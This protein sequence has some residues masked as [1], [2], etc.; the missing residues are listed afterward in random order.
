[1]SKTVKA[2]AWLSVP[3]PPGSRTFPGLLKVTPTGKKVVSLELPVQFFLDTSTTEVIDTAARKGYQRPT[4]HSRGKE[5][6]EHL[7][8]HEVV[9]PVIG[10]IRDVDMKQVYVRDLHGVNAQKTGHVRVT[11]PPNV[12]TRLIDGG[13]RQ[14]GYHYF[15]LRGLD[16]PEDTVSV[17]LHLGLTESA[18][19]D[20]FRTIN[21]KAVRLATNH[22]R[23]LEAY[24]YEGMSEKEA[25]NTLEPKEYDSF[26]RDRIIEDLE[27]T[28]FWSG[29]MIHRTGTNSGQKIT[30]SAMHGSLEPVTNS[31]NLWDAKVDDFVAILT[32]Y[33]EAIAYVFPDAF[34]GGPER[35]KDWAI[36]GGSAV[37]G[38][39]L[40]LPRL[41]DLLQRA[42][43]P[44]DD[45]SS[46]HPYLKRLEELEYSNG[47]Q[48]PEDVSGLNF[49]TKGKDGAVGRFSNRGNYVN[50]AEL[51]FNTITSD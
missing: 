10:N 20:E 37:N 36:Q 7:H 28:E 4:Q 25:K 18:E 5:L 40:I 11:L 49:F 33:W 35:A 14:L 46:Y 31:P 47:H 16:A 22:T 50:L 26:I 45:S 2:P 17:Y 44:R 8:S 9:P 48:V 27:T 39:H 21:G 29:G 42:G 1:M 30:Y 41:L 6:A 32:A 43:L 13:H 3:P 15:V 12:V 23:Q 51:M 38:F 24:E 19:S 34:E